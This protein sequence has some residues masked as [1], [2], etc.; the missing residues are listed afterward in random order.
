MTMLQLKFTAGLT[1]LCLL[2]SL[3]SGCRSINVDGH[4]IAL[5]GEPDAYAPQN[6]SQASP[7]LPANLRRVAVL[8]LTA[9]DNELAAETRVQL[10]Q[11]LPVELN[12]TEQFEVVPVTPEQLRRW[13]GRSRW[14]V[15]D[16]LPP[17]LLKH[18]QTRLEC[19]AVI[20]AHL[21][22]YRPYPPLMVGWKLHLVDARDAQIWWAS[23]VIFDAGDE[24]VAQSAVQFE[25]EFQTGR[26]PTADPATILRSPGRFGQYTLA[27]SLGTLQRHEKNH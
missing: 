21:T 23:D 13:T 27:A 16:T 6:L 7:W 15:T 2:A 8:P 20:F 3:G 10:E 5:G 1:G 24:R 19:D 9:T 17:D 25:R 11:L 4:E 26:V 22:A 18:L 12:R 14:G